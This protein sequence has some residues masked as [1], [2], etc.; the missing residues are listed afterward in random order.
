[1]S[2][3]APQHEP[4]HEEIRSP[5]MD[6]LD[7]IAAKNDRHRQTVERLHGFTVPDHQ[8]DEDDE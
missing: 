7:A 3:T 8:E 1:M 2:D 5:E 6:L 4:E